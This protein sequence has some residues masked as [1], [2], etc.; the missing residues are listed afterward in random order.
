MSNMG[1]RK[2]T[3]QSMMLAKT[4]P[5]DVHDGAINEV[6]EPFDI[7]DDSFDVD[8]SFDSAS[9]LKNTLIEANTL[10]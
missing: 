7:S 10:C 4:I 3:R 6:H 2:D 8:K 5:A 9:S 1:S